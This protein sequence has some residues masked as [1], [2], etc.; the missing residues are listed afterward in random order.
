MWLGPHISPRRTGK[1][2]T[3]GVGRDGRRDVAKGNETTRSC[4]PGDEGWQKVPSNSPDGLRYQ[5]PWSG[6]P[7]A[8]HGER[9]HGKS[10][11]CPALHEGREV[12]A[13]VRVDPEVPGSIT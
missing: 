4:E 13:G 11:K 5:L 6:E 2:G 7:L 3:R 8:N 9:D 12:S 10:G 1:H